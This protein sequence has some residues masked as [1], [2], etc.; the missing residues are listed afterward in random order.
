MS[1]GN[2]TVEAI[3]EALR[4]GPRDLARSPRAAVGAA[5]TQLLRSVRHQTT[6]RV[7]SAEYRI[8]DLARVSGVTTRNIRAYQERGLLHPPR[9]SG[10]V[11]LFDDTHLS[12]LRL[13]SS[14]LERG[15]STAHI[16]E[17]LGAWEHGRD[18][19]DVLGLEKALVSPW[20]ED[21]PTT[22]PLREIRDLAGGG[23]DLQ[24]LVDAGLVR[25]KGGANAVAE[26]PKLLRA[27]A[28][29]RTYGMP[30]AIVLELHEQL[31][32]AID[33]ISRLLVRAGA[34]HVAEQFDPASEPS[35]QDVTELITM[36]VRF[37]TL[38]MTSVTASIAASLEHTVE[39][40]LGDYLIQLM[41]PEAARKSAG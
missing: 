34:K 16:L 1:E 29:M 39:D 37:R 6:P 4:R 8:D 3:L 12:R 23:E 40:M 2:A 10:R 30:L 36:L 21:R 27:F 7:T 15:Y 18:L 25:L 17:M 41:G 14:M 28:E 9:R 32:P 24:R 38:A 20:G 11:A 19:A 22:M 33:E 26:R 35:S 13:I 5:V 31:Q